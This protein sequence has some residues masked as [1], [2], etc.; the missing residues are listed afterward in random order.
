MIFNIHCTPFGQIKKLSSYLFHVEKILQTRYLW[1]IEHF[2]IKRVM[3]VSLPF[4]NII[5]LLVQLELLFE[6]IHA[7]N[8]SCSWDKVVYSVCLDGR[9]ARCRLDVRSINTYISVSSDENISA[10]I[11]LVHGFQLIFSQYFSPVFD[12]FGH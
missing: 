5:S 12:L 4:G 1:V 7:L 6:Y 2:S 10:F 11:G 8:V 3:R 9:Q